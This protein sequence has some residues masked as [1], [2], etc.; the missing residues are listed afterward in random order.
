MRR[1]RPASGAVPSAQIAFD[2]EEVSFPSGEAHHVQESPSL[3]ALPTIGSHIPVYTVFLRRSD[4]FAA[5]DLPAI[6]SAKDVAQLLDDYLKD[7][8]REH[9]VIGVLGTIGR[10]TVLTTTD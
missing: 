5:R 4:A 9:F 8:D 3:P 7:T 10:K 1:H 2:F 6:R